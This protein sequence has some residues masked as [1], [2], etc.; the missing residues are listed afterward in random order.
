MSCSVED[1][2]DGEKSVKLLTNAISDNTMNF[3]SKLT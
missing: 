1:L 3:M 2:F